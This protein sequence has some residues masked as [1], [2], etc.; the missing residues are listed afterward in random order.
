M[1]LWI[2]WLLNLKNS[3]FDTIKLVKNA[4]NDKYKY[5]RYGIGL[6]KDGTFSVGNGFGKNVIIFGVDMSSSVHVDNKKKDNFWWRCC[7]RIRQYNINCRKRVFNQS[8]RA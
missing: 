5:S 2:W 3:L 4:D 7:T 6:D 8:Y 1:G